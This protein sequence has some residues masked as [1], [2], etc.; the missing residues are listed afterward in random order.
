MRVSGGSPAPSTP[1]PC[2]THT[3]RS[4]PGPDSLFP[5]GTSCGDAS[6]QFH[7]SMGARCEFSGG[8]RGKAQGELVILRD[9]AVWAP[10]PGFP[11]TQE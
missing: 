11:Q 8:C 6:S 9:R 2:H 3:H 4:L 5:G 7:K 1:F 10:S